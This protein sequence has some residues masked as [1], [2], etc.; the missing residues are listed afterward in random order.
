MGADLEHP[1]VTSHMATWQQCL[2][3]LV[4][5]TLSDGISEVLEALTSCNDHLTGFFPTT[6]SPMGLAVVA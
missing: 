3:S 2:Q 1:L 5:S 4:S 6:V